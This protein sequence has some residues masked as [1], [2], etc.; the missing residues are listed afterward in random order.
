MEGG[1]GGFMYHKC[2]IGYIWFEFHVQ[3]I[4]LGRGGNGEGE[5]VSFELE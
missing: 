3:L 2:Q 5:G 4:M 1:W